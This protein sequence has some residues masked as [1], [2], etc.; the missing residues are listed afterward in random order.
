VIEERQNGTAAAD[1]SHQY[2]WSHCQVVSASYGVDASEH[3][4]GDRTDASRR[5]GHQDHLAGHSSIV[6]HGPCD[7]PEIHYQL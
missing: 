5:A 2:V 7:P 1:V 4:L 3:G 6:V